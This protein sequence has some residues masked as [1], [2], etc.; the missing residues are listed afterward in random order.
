MDA[1][2]KGI[3]G[4]LDTDRLDA[5]AGTLGGLGCTGVYHG[6]APKD[7]AVPYLRFH[8]LAAPLSPTMGDNGVD[9]V[10]AV[11]MVLA[12]DEGADQ[13]RA[14]AL[15]GRVRELLHKKPLTLDGGVTHLRTLL[16]RHL[17][18]PDHGEG[19]QLQQI[20]AN[21]RVWVYQ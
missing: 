16:D 19:R 5:S 10:E 7:A 18:L 4:V 6:I 21:Y 14:G 2:D 20:G 11:Y 9:T 12:V 1:I 17:D 8:Q 15:A 3:F 13:L